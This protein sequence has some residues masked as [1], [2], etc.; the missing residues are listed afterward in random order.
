MLDKLSLQRTF[1][2]LE[3]AIGLSHQRQSLIATNLSNLDTP[4]YRAKDL[5]FR[6]AM[7]R[8]LNE[9]PPGR[10]IS[11]NPNH[12]GRG[13]GTADDAPFEEEGKWNGI[14]WVS[15]DE[16]MVKLTQNTLVYR[17][18]TEALLR[19][20]TLIREVIKESSR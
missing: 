19:K 4:G 15:L 7:D 11:T 12:M 14:N 3:K 2:A 8:A 5:D 10:L 18:S 1:Q 16:T 13:G 20:I 9:T 17:A 6:T